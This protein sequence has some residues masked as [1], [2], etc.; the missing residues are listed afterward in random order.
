MGEVLT[1]NQAFLTVDDT[2]QPSRAV[3]GVRQHI[4]EQVAPDIRG[5]GRITPRMTY[6]QHPVET[7][8]GNCA[9]RSKGDGLENIPE[10]LQVQSAGHHAKKLAIRTGNLA[11]KVNAPGACATV[12]HRRAHA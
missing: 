7:K 1:C 8:E 11:R 12:D 5:S 3:I 9:V 6:K 10:V 2:C 4:L